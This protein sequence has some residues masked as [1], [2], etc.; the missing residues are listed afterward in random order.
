MSLGRPRGGVIGGIGAPVIDKG[1]SLGHDL[2]ATLPLSKYSLSAM[3]S[4]P[5]C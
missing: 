4:A 3:N 2:S 5:A 1:P